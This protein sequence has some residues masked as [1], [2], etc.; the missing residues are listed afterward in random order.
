MYVL[1]ALRFEVMIISNIETLP[2]TS[3]LRLGMYEKQ[4]QLQQQLAG[5][6]DRVCSTK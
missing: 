3:K 5:A 4:M 1:Y 6:S 2:K